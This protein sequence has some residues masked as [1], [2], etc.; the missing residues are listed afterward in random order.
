M[1]TR[2][3]TAPQPLHIVRGRD[4]LRRRLLA[5]ADIAAGLCF[6][7]G[8]HFAGATHEELLAAAAL[9]P[10]WPLLAKLHGLYDRDHRAL[11]TTTADEL[12]T[13]AGWGLVGTAL[14]AAL[15]C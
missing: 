12:A 4:V 7:I 15:S 5:L 14:V 2:P 11:Y 13:L 6:L 9:L 1:S 10:I 3:E 8:L